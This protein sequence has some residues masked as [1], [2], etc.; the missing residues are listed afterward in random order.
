MALDNLSLIT[1]VKKLKE[2]IT[3]TFLDKPYPLSE[4]QFAFPYHSQNKH[5]SII[6]SLD[7]NNPFISYS[8]NKYIKIN[9]NTPFFNSLKKLTGTKIINIKKINNDRIV[10]IETKVENT[11][12][13]QSIYT[14]F[15]I[16][17][18]LF[19]QI[20]N[21]YLVSLPDN[22]ILSLYKQHYDILSPKYVTRNQ[23]FII[24]SNEKPDISNCNSLEE[25]K[26]YLSFST[27]KLFETYSNNVGYINAKNKLIN[28]QNLYLIDNKI[29][30]FHFDLENAKKIEVNEIFD[31]FN[32]NQEKQARLQNNKDLIKEITK[33]LTMLKKKI[34]HIKSDLEKAKSHLIYK[35]YGQEILLH[36]LEINPNDKKCEFDNY[37][38]DLD[39]KLDVISNA[40]KYFKLYKKA[41]IAISKLEPLINQCNL[42][43]QYLEN[44]LL[45]IDK[46]NNQDVLQIKQ[47]LYLEGYLKNK[48]NK[49]KVKVS[50]VT[51]H[52]FRK[53]NIL[54]GF[55]LNEFQNEELTFKI[56]RKS[57]VFFHVKDYPG[58]HVILLEGDKKE[59]Y[60]LA[61]EL[62][63]YLSNLNS[64]DVMYT[65]KENVKKNNQKRGLVNLLEYKIITIHKIDENHINLF[66]SA[67][68][69][70]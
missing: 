19:P 32:S 41:K 17:I 68:K 33:N 20:P 22:K 7:G 30:P 15:V 43:I 49:T 54:I 14:G 5:G 18:E 59:G 29:E 57:N 40:N 70:H 24:N 53:D 63:L 38:I 27:F 67:L 69:L 56:A 65:L 9:L 51:P 50:K 66:K 1:I 2:E 6:I 12:I 61:S 16:Y 13:I 64:G 23:V 46:A 4:T 44:K 25:I 35:E 21:L 48:N 26:K 45:Q 3:G 8:N 37:K 42:D 55:G 28:S 58:A 52:Y 60:L 10:K 34:N 11:S 47:E 62:A 36:Q 31:I 39:P